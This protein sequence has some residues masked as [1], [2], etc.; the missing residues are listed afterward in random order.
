MIFIPDR[1]EDGYGLSQRGIDQLHDQGVSLLITADCGISA[2][3]Q[4]EYAKSLGMDVVV[5]DHHEPEGPLPDA[6]TVVNPKQGECPFGNEDLCGAG[7]VFH[8]IVA[9]R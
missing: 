3:S 5:T 4:V 7:V 8:L 6:L 9:L 1:N 2:V